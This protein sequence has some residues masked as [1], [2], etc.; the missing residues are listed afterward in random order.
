M[1]TVMEAEID[2]KQKMFEDL[3]LAVESAFDPIS[4]ERKLVLL[5]NH[6]DILHP[7][8][9]I[10]VAQ[11]KRI[12]GDILDVY[13]DED[14]FVGD[15]D[16]GDA[17]EWQIERPKCTLVIMPIKHQIKQFFE[18]PNVFEKIQAHTAIIEA[19]P[20]LNHFIKGTLS[21]YKL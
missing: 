16:T 6:M 10:D 12:G 19:D 3:T 20:K 17:P 15:D 13:A 5:L 7:I 21:H 14:D 11:N 2:N 4:T 1:K 9:R 8:Q 18:L